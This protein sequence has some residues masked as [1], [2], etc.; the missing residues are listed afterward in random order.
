MMNKLDKTQTN[1]LQKCID[2]AQ[3]ISIVVHINPDGD[4]VGSGTAM[5]DFL[6]RRDRDAMLILPHECPDAVS[7]LIGDNLADK[8]LVHEREPSATEERLLASDLLICQDFNGFA[9]AGDLKDTLEACSA[10]KI[11]IDHHLN[12]D[13]ERFG[14]V[15]SDTEVSSASEYLYY[16]LKALPCIDGDISRLSGGCLASLMTGMTTDTNNFANSVYP[17]TLQMASELIAAGV[18]RDYI[19]DNVYNSFREE[20]IRL[21]GLLLGKE[22]RISTDGV[23]YMVLD[24]GT[25]REYNIREGETEGFVNI[26]LS[27]RKV[28][29]SIFLKE[30]KDF[31]RVSIRSKKGTSANRC[32]AAYFNGGGHELASG[33]RL[34]KADGI[35]DAEKARNYI[36]EVTHKFMTEYENQ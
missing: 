14:L 2:K 32:A 23:A 17:G 21:M 13:R 26:P 29:M 11:L 10:E 3:R 34:F 18:D 30:D 8:V 33:G 31:F 19:L 20:R 4:A 5:L 27:I 6:L 24:C 1:L 9:R 25:M 15:F 16:I 12:P 36:E 22:M 7:F 35:T 28:R